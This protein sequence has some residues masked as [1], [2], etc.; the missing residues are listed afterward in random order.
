[1]DDPVNEDSNTQLVVEE[2]DKLV[3]DILKYEDGDSVYDID[4]DIE[5][6]IEELGGD[7]ADAGRKNDL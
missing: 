7:I 4:E 6:N 5:I 1:M 3:K 2:Q